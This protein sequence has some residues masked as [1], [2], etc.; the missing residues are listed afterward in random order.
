MEFLNPA[1]LYTFLLLPLLLLA[2]LIRGRPRRMVRV[3]YRHPANRQT[4]GQSLGRPG[5]MVRGYR[6]RQEGQEA[7][8]QG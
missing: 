2:Y 5:L 6:E 8:G 3:G 1:A 4:G 7:F